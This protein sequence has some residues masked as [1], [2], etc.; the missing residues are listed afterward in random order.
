MLRL[1]DPSKLGH[2]LFGLLV[3]AA[4]AS[5]QDAVTDEYGTPAPRAESAGRMRLPEGFRV[6]LV[7]AEPDVRQPI[8]FTID[9]R[10]RLWVAECYSYPGWSLEGKD[11]I[12]VLEDGD[13][14]GRFE[15]RKVFKDG[16]RNLTGLELGF[17][18]AWICSTPELLFIPDRDGDDS[19]DGAPEVVLDGWDMLTSQHNVFSTLT[20]GPDGWLYGCNG[21]LSESL[22]GKPGAPERDRVPLNCGVWR[23]HPTERRFEVVAWGTTNPWGLDFDDHG[24]MFI[25]NCVIPHLFHVVPGAHF[26]RM[27]GNDFNPHL[28]GLMETCADHI[29]WAGGAWQSSRGGEGKHGEAGGGH[30]HVGAMVYLGDNWPER[31][32]NGLFT[33]N[34]HGN[35]V[36]HDSLERQGSGYVARHEQDFLLAGDKWFRGLELKYGP[37]GGVF[38]TDWSDAGECHDTD[39]HGAHHESG[40]IY[41]VRYGE[42]EPRR[43]DLERS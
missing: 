31:Y 15:G 6:D 35:R 30:A 42:P 19:P 12:V 32:R 18:G 5:A 25:T 33:C 11:R 21:I 8:A 43:V 36:N 38:V 1:P 37:D 17:G 39:R 13:G 22:V 14:D 27:F 7:A 10:G 40:R 9:P 41:R 28:Y 26:Q 16:I 24:E 23:Y 3:I 20:W 34:I 29:H 2:G 4:S